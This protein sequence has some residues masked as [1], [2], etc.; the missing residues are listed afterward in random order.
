M[1]QFKII[2]AITLA[3][4]LQSALRHVLPVSRYVDLPLILAIYYALRRELNA[5]LVIAAVA[6]VATDS[7]SGG[8]LGAG[9][10]ARLVAAFLTVSLSLRVML[11]NPLAR[12]PA[13]A[14]A[15]AI[16]TLV[17]LGL[18]QLWG[19]PLPE[20]PLVE[21]VAKQLFATTAVGSLLMLVVDNFFSERARQRR[22]VAARRKFSRR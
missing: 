18:H 6:G 12:V 2:L 7:L 9:G 14:G 5:C 4:V 11:D 16:S 21:W 17:Y 19:Q 22:Q 3:V 13:L 1:R 15:T 20:F 10:C 8:L